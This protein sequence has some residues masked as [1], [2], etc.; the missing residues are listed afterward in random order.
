MKILKTGICFIIFSLLVA[1]TF[2]QDVNIPNN[3]EIKIVNEDSLIIAHVLIYQKK[4]IEINHSKRYYWYNNVTINSNVGGYH[5]KLLHGNYKVLV[6]TNLVLSGKLEKGLK[7][8]QWVRWRPNGEFLETVE[9]K[10][11][12]KQG[13]KLE[14]DSSGNVVGIYSYKNG[15]KDG[16]YKK[17]DSDGNLIEKGKY[18][19]DKKE[20]RVKIFT[21]G[22]KSVK[23][24]NNGELIFKLKKKSLDTNEGIIEPSKQNDISKPSESKW[25]KSIFKK[26]KTIES[27][28]SN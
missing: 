1:N 12:Y 2:G 24:Y 22:K 23:K 13:K 16:K 14:Y 19:L 9:Y 27:L 5:G 3:K 28:E 17:W 11:G 20:G 4:P 21:N 7:V 6:G 18:R 8:G 10:K 26:R 15:R 25:W